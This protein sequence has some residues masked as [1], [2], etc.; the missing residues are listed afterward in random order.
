MPRLEIVFKRKVDCGAVVEGVSVTGIT[1][2]HRV[3]LKRSRTCE[4]FFKCTIVYIKFKCDRIDTFKHA[5]MGTGLVEQS[6]EWI[7]R[8]HIVVCVCVCV[9]NVICD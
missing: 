9:T 5:P 2:E 1:T 3:E 6:G 4:E 8:G 7:D